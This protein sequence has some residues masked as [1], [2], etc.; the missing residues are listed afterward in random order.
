MLSRAEQKRIRALRQRKNRD[1]ER[2]FLAEGVRIVEDLLAARIEVDLI[3]ASSS[4][5]DTERG[6]RLAAKLAGIAPVRR[7]GDAELARLAATETPQGVLVVGVQ[8]RSDWPSL[9]AESDGRPWL[10]LDAV[11]DPGNFGTLVRSADAFGATGVVTLP[12]TVDPWNPKSVRAAAGSTFRVPVWTAE[13]A[14]AFERLRRL[15][16]RILAADAAGRAIG[17]EDLERPVALVVGNEGAGLNDAVRAAADG[18][19]GVPMPGRAESLNVAVA[20]GILLYLL[21]RKA[22]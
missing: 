12:G 10:V 15:G 18:V 4:L 16:I 1:R 9:A 3:V 14:A 2:R 20:A 21:T 22:R 19:V 13:P 5:E 7:V 17:G 8:P 6:R 11:Q